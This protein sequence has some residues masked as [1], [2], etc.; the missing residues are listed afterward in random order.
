MQRSGPGGV[1]MAPAAVARPLAVVAISY[2]AGSIPFSNLMARWRADVDLRDVGTGTV[3]G[4]SLYD[5]AGF[6][7]LALA[8]VADVAKGAVGPLLAGPD[9]PVLSAVAGGAGVCGHNWSVWL[10]G[11]GGRGISPA[12]GALLVRD[13]PGAVT[14]MTGLSFKAVHATGLGGFLADVALVPVLAMTRGPAGALMGAGV[15]LPMLVK[16]LVGNRPPVRR[17]V[18]AYASRL[19]FDRDAGEER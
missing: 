8:G 19:V 12:M 14:L 9:R 5:V 11:A 16:R 17:D 3:S 18:A 7:A 4:T 13:P 6:G 1:L 15:V 10:G 2:L